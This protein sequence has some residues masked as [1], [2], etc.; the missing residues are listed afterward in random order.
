M[1]LYLFN[2]DTDMALANHRPNYIAPARVRQMAEELALLPVWYATPGSRVLAPSAYNLRFLKEI[3]RQFGMDVEVMTL[4]EVAEHATLELSPWGWNKALTARLAEAGVAAG[5]LPTAEEL[6]H[7]RSRNSRTWVAQALARL[8]QQEGCCGASAN[9]YTLEEC[10]AYV[11]EHDCCL[12]KEP[13]SSSGKGLNWCRKGFN[14]S[15]AGW[16]RRVL[17]EQGAVAASPIYNKVWDFAM[18]FR[19]ENGR[20]SFEGYSWFSTNQSGAYTGNRLLDTTEI[21]CELLRY[22]PPHLLKAVRHMLE[23]EILPP[24]AQLPTAY[25]GV[26]MMVCRDESGAC[27]LH[28]CVEINPRMNM[29]VLALHL[30]R[31]YLAAGSHGRFMIEYHPLSDELH[32]TVQ[33]FSANNPLNVEKGRIV[34]GFMPLVPLTPA[35]HYLA[36][37][38]VH[39][40]PSINQGSQQAT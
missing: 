33:R 37:V 34:S 27:C 12:L 3:K 39:E 2:P 10:R 40:R 8:T 36:Y 6:E 38:D 32:E 9:L 18:E 4:P 14:D 28:P 11:Q 7:Y 17:A 21:E 19:V 16:C 15:I 20:A 22:L 26:D 23:E 13:W 1:K 35:S 25:I 24:Y 30:Q 5:L 29:G 31:N